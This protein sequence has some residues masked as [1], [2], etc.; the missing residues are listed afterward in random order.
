M[1]EKFGIDKHGDIEFKKGE[2]GKG[3][4]ED[5]ERECQLCGTTEN[6]KTF[7]GGTV[8]RMCEDCHETIEN[9][10]PFHT[11]Q[12]KFRMKLMDVDIPED[13]EEDTDIDLLLNSIEWKLAKS[14]LFYKEAQNQLEILKEDVLGS[15]TDG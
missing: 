13:R 2:P 14:E 5:R 3:M 11:N 12:L 4:T 8:G 9:W 10:A 1:D 15:D 7:I 6:V